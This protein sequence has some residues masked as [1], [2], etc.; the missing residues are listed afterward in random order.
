MGLDIDVTKVM[1]TWIHQM[2]YPVVKFEY[3]NS[4]LDV[5]QSH[6]LID[7]EAVAPPSDYK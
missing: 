2:G 6:F 1:N 4:K 5:C 7:P 3:T